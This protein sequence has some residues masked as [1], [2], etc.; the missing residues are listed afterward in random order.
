LPR[1]GVA[2]LYVAGFLLESAG[3]SLARKAT[4]LYRR[5]QY[6]YAPDAADAIVH[7]LAQCLKGP[8]RG[9]VA[10]N[11]CDETSRTCRELYARAYKATRD[12]RFKVPFEIPVVADVA[13]DFIRHRTLQLRYPLGMLT[14]SNVGLRASGFR[15]T[16]GFEAALEL[17]LAGK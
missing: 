11:I 1:H 13:K 15:F 8:P 17:A 7:L 5:T 10:Y 16:T 2:G 4:T 6:I 12:P 9:I 3:W 14:I